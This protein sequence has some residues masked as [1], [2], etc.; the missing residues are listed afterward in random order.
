MNL[1]YVTTV[2]LGINYHKITM[3]ERIDMSDS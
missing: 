2:C 1:Y 3:L